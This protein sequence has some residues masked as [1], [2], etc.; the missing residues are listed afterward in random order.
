MH[1]GQLENSE[2]FNNCATPICRIFEP[3]DTSHRV[4]LELRGI[5]RGDKNQYPQIQC[6]TIIKEPV[7]TRGH[8]PRYNIFMNVHML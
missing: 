3:R 1:Y 5:R 2:Y 8:I 4:Q 6:R 7:H